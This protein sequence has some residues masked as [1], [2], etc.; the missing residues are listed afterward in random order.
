MVCRENNLQHEFFVTELL[1]LYVFYQKVF[2]SIF[3]MKLMV[4]SHSYNS[5]RIPMVPE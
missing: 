3:L 1:A 4:F 5:P 2:Y